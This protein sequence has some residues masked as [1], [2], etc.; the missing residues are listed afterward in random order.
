[1]KKAIK[2]VSISL[3]VVIVVIASVFAALFFLADDDFIDV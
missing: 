2:I 1:M 3:G